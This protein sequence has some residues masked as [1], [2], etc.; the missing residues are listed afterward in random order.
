MKAKRVAYYLWVRWR[1]G[2]VDCFELDKTSFDYWRFIWN[3]TLIK[4]FTL[5]TP[6]GQNIRINAED[7]SAAKLLTKEIGSA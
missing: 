1:S 3:E 5:R 7:I 4:K 2:A 6:T